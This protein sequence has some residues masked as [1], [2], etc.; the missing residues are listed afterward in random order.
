M[1]LNYRVSYVDAVGVTRDIDLLP[2]D[3]GVRID[4]RTEINRNTTST[5][6]YENVTQNTLRFVTFDCY[7]QATA[8]H[9]VET[10]MSQAQI[11]VPFSFS[12]DSTRTPFTTISLG[13]AGNSAIYTVASTADF[14][15]GDE[16]IV[17]DA[18]LTK[19]DVANVLD[20]AGVI[21]ADYP[22]THTY[23]IGDTL[24]W[25]Y[26]FPALL[27]LDDTFNPDRDGSFYHHKFNCVEVRDV[28]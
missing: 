9:R 20:T 4:W 21:T 11:G 26:Y 17:S 12:K 16:I 15:V 14:L 13:N 2:G 27:L 24:S 22:S 5:G 10:W 19:W 7:F 23:A 18:F 6:I 25:Y 3:D 8:F 1:S 28:S